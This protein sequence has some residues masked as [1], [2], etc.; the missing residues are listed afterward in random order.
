MRASALALTVNFVALFWFSKICSI[1]GVR[2]VD[3]SVRNV[4]A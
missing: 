4:D 1:A 2:A 3:F